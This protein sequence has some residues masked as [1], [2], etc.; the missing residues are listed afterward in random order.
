MVDWWETAGVG[1]AL[2]ERNGKVNVAF[3]IQDEDRVQG[4][5]DLSMRNV[6]QGYADSILLV[7]QVLRNAGQW[8]W[9]LQ[10]RLD[11]DTKEILDANDFE[12]LEIGEDNMKYWEGQADKYGFDAY[13]EEGTFWVVARDV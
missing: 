8:D 1:P 13:T 5:I 11:A 3:G 6:P 7:A 2:N 9:N 12:V 4:N 10:R